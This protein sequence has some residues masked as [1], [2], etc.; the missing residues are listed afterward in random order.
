MAKTR[1]LS[2]DRRWQLAGIG[3]LILVTVIVA[4]AFG[5][6]RTRHQ[7]DVPVLSSAPL[8]NQK[9]KKIVVIGDSFTE[10]TPQGGVGANGWQQLAF[11]Q[12][13][14]DGIDITPSVAAEG[15]AGYAA[16]GYRGTNFV[17]EAHRV[18]A[19]D[20]NLV[21]IFGGMNDATMDPKSE[22]SAVSDT[23]GF[24]RTTAPQAQ[25]IVVGPVSPVADPPPELTRVRDLIR[26]QA[27]QVGAIFVDPIADR[28]FDN[29]PS[30]I[31]PDGLHPTDE[32][33]AYMSEKLLP[34]IRDALAPP[35]A[36]R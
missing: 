12:L 9:P 31:G 33:H 16:R 5:V 2:S 4:A 19:P 8:A 15:S 6:A 3:A 25:L 24:V 34:V 21:I 11:R 18:L 29:L 26:D 10:G 14:T 22:A 17:E 32:G 13:R 27:N 7:Q 30:S 28:W 1:R 20:D 35:G 36:P 23:F